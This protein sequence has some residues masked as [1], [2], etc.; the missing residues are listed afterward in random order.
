MIDLVYV[1]DEV[2]VTKASPVKKIDEETKSLAEQMIEAVQRYEGIG[3]AAPQVNVLTRMFIVYLRDDKPRVFINPEILGTSLEETVLEEG[4]LS[5]PGIYADVK[6]PVGVSVQA[7]DERGKPFT[8]NADGML[9]R[10]IQHEYDHLNG[11]LFT[12]HLSEGKRQRLMKKY[13]KPVS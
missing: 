5:I 7:F 8:L 6:R 9:A 12:E 11:V 3:L 4:C 1:P 2:L 13:Q 10:V